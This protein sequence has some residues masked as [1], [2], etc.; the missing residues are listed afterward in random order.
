MRR[1]SGLGGRREELVDEL[2]EEVAELVAK[3]V[4]EGGEEVGRDGGVVRIG[5]SLYDLMVEHTFSVIDELPTGSDESGAQDD[6]DSDVD[7]RVRHGFIFLVVNC[8]CKGSWFYRG[9]QAGLANTLPNQELPSG[10]KN[11]S[12]N[13]MRKSPS[14]LPREGTSVVWGTGVSGGVDVGGCGIMM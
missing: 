11:L 6:F 12:M 14:L 10:G 2:D 8:W 5:H 1:R 4:A 13:L 3:G 9:R 7:D